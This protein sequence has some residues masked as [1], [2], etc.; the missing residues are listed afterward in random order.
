VD[1]IT[2]GGAYEAVKATKQLLTA[3]FEA[4]VD[5]EARPK[6]QEARIK[7]DEILMALYATREQLFELQEERN[8]IKLQLDAANAWQAKLDRYKLV[9]T[10][11]GAVVYRS[12]DDP[13]HFICPSCTNK[14]E[15][16]PLQNNR[17][18]SGKFRCTGCEA[19][20]PIEPKT[21][22][23]PLSYPKNTVA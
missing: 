8:S 10:D 20:F 17:T 4:K 18:D 22:S 21:P 3:A 13:V 12:T 1:P 6:I 11:G 9:L 15:I 2:I 16:H 7:L 14:K 23:A 19:E 5:A